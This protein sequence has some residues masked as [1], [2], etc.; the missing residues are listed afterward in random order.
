MKKIV[1]TLLLFLPVIAGFAQRNGGDVDKDRQIKGVIIAGLNLSQVDGDEVYGF[2][3]GGLNAGFG[4]TLPLGKG[5]SFGIETLFN[6]KGAYRKFSP[7]YDSTGKPYYHLK[8]D[9]LEVPVMFSFEDRHIWTI[10]L[11]FSWGRRVSYRE[12]EHGLVMDSS[13][14]YSKNDFD[15]LL[16]L[17]LRVWKHLKVDVRY[18][19]SMAKIRTRNYGPTLAGEE[20][21]RDQY[22][23]LISLRLLYVL[24]E[25]YVPAPKKKSHKK[26]NTTAYIAPWNL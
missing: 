16:D 23:N 11:G 1:F 8:L 22:H 14:Q 2:S 3:K 17:Q 6:Q 25:K 7:E 12:I 21:T 24:N 26:T 5:F 13:S 10:G 18:A 4:A 15:V 9:Y 19:Y 20:W